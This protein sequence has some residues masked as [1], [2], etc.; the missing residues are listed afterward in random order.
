MSKKQMLKNAK[1]TLKIVE[2]KK[3]KGRLILRLT[4]LRRVNYA[5]K[6]KSN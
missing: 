4:L 1:C 2:R 6:T 5:P 3:V